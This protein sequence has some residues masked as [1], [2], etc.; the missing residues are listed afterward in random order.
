MQGQGWGGG[1][2]TRGARVFCR[3]GPG[4]EHRAK[5]NVKGKRLQR[6]LAASVFTNPAAE[7]G[8]GNIPPALSRSLEAGW[9]AVC[10]VRLFAWKSEQER[11]LTQDHRAMPGQDGGAEPPTRASPRLHGGLPCGIWVTVTTMTKSMEMAGMSARA[12]FTLQGRCH[13]RVSSRPLARPCPPTSAHS[14]C[15]KRTRASCRGPGS[16][17]K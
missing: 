1:P 9:F 6:T 12:G 17:E 3:R 10:G 8:R 16:R 11:C 4:E 2:R 13:F 5:L 14:P 15:Q 7:G